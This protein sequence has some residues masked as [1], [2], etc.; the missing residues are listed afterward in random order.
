MEYLID[1][2][3]QRSMREDLNVTFLRPASPEVLSSLRHLG[4][5]LRRGPTE[6]AGAHAGGGHHRR[7]STLVGYPEDARLRYLLDAEAHPFP[8]PQQG[9]S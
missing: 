1:V 6:R 2:Q 8:V 4:S 7:D 3:F 5:A 9:C